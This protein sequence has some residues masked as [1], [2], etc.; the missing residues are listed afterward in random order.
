MYRSTALVAGQRHAD[1]LAEAARQRLAGEMR[2]GSA[3]TEPAE[4]DR[5]WRL[6]LAGRLLAAR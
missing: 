1:L 5:S 3:E 6:L 2:Q 4:R